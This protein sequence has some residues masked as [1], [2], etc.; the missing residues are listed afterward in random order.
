MTLALDSL[1][2]T[3]EGTLLADG[4]NPF[5]FD[6]P[7]DH[8]PATLLLDGA[9]GMVTTSL[10]G[11]L[12]GLRLTFHRFGDPGEPVDLR[13]TQNGDDCE[14]CALRFSGGGA[15]LADGQ[16][17]VRALADSR[18]FPERRSPDP[19]D[20][21]L[22]HR[23]RAENVAIGAVETGAEECTAE[24]LDFAA[25]H[26][27]RRRDPAHRGPVELVEAARQL[28]TC[29]GH[30]VWEIPDDWKY[31]FTGLRFEQRRRVAGRE[32]I[33]LRASRM[34]LHRRR[35]DV[36]VELEAAD[37]TVG[38]VGIEGLVAAPRIYEHLRWSQA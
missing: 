3:T 33:R 37:G 25:E 30:E 19:V 7:L 12:A 24:M 8:L 34:S 1:V 6:H 11:Q 13:L 15:I 20:R 27:L 17:A 9:V 36:L 35:L 29:L 22:V 14:R 31:V 16:V 38:S 2:F 18:A 4:E 5:F 26:P 21:E 23:H 32:P 28:T 10:P